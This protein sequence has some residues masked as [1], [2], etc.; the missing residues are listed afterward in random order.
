MKQP[1][2]IEQLLQLILMWDLTMIHVQ[3]LQDGLARIFFR[4][5]L[6]PEHQMF[7]TVRVR[8][9]QHIMERIKA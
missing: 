3:P 9:H 2:T 4:D 7:F 6:D 1:Q 5:P 8:I